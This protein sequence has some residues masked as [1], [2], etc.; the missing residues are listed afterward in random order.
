ML[1]VEQATAITLEH[2]AALG[3][4]EVDNLQRESESQPRPKK[5]TN[6]HSGT[7]APQLASFPGSLVQSLIEING[8]SENK[9]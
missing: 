4:T 1:P 2:A 5:K 6:I 8:E 7:T 3:V 9:G